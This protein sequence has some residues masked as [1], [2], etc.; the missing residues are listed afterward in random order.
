M[1]VE[2]QGHKTL[3]LHCLI[4]VRGWNTTLK[5]LHSKC[6]TTRE[7]WER[8][9]LNYGKQIMTAKFLSNRKKMQTWG[10]FQIVH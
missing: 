8:G 2:E 1:T 6:K 5:G 7:K 10:T 9:M 3:H 4:W